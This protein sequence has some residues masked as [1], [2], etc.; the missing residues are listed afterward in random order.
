MSWS[1]TSFLDHVARMVIEP[2]ERWS[3]D[4]AQ[5]TPLVLTIFVAYLYVILRPRN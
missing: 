5:M 1:A 2:L 4:G 3:F